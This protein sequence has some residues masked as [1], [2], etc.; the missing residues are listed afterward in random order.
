M[1]S[2]ARLEVGAVGQLQLGEGASKRHE[3]QVKVF[4]RGHPEERE[5]ES[6]DEGKER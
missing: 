1:K 6:E 2:G 5:R 3:G 4:D